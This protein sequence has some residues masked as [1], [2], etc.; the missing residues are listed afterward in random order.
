MRKTDRL[1]SFIM[2]INRI[3][4]IE[5]QHLRWRSHGWP[6]GTLAGASF[7]QCMSVW[8][9]FPVSVWGKGLFGWFGELRR[10]GWLP[11]V[12]CD[13]Q[14][15][16]KKSFRAK[17]CWIPSLG[18]IPFFLFIRKMRDSFP[19]SKPWRPCFLE[20]TASVFAFPVTASPGIGS[21]GRSQRERQGHSRPKS[22]SG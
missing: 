16:D 3:C 9:L 5:H 18:R 14:C 20:S 21:H 4:H 22:C 17:K 19:A 6:C 8:S 13:A 1:L 7:P 11:L 10:I 15:Y 12:R 2:I